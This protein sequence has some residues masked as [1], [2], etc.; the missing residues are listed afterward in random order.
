MVQLESTHIK[1]QVG[2]EPHASCAL[3][4]WKYLT[5]IRELLVIPHR[6]AVL[7][8]PAGL[9]A[10]PDPGSSKN[11]GREGWKARLALLH[12]CVEHVMFLAPNPSSKEIWNH[13][14]SVGCWR[15]SG[16]IRNIG[17]GGWSLESRILLLLPW[18]VTNLLPFHQRGWAES[19]G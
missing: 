19:K 15:Y 10:S 11:R 7:L 3:R 14:F 17:R 2:P 4:W 9:E 5:V 12:L 18:R 13:P 6:V 1:T 16:S 8:L